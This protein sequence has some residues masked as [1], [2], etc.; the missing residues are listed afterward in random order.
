MATSGSDADLIVLV[1]DREALLNTGAANNKESLA[2]S[3]ESDALRAGLFIDVLGGITVEVAVV[4]TPS[5]KRVFARLRSK[6]PELSESEIM[7]LGRLRTG[8]LLMQSDQYLTRSGVALNDPVLDTY[9]SVRHFLFALIY[10]HKAIRALDLADIPQTLHLGRLSVEMAYLAYFASEGFPYLGPKW[11]AQIGHARGASARVSRH[12][13]LKD[14]LELLFPAYPVGPG[15]ARQYLRAVTEF[16][17]AMR[18]L[19]EQKTMFRI[20][21]NVCRQIYP[22]AGDS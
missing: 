9:C 18:A 20:A 10:R 14:G 13:L 19:I 5:I 8:W 15:E 12:P 2:F 22:V 3:N 6:G 4:I 21:F 7:M 11:L 1:D 17:T 16:L